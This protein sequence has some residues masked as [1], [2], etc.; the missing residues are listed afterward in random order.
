[1]VQNCLKNNTLTYNCVCTS[2]G[3]AVD[4][5]HVTFVEIKLFSLK[6][7]VWEPR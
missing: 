4:A 6:S 2:I 7:K 3:A 1:M 5:E